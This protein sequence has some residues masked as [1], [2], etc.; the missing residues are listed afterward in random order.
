M[1]K[2][3]AER[4]RKGGKARSEALSPQRRGEIAKAAADTR[5]KNHWL[6][7]Q[8]SSESR[9]KK[10]AHGWRGMAAAIVEHFRSEPLNSYTLNQCSDV[11][12]A[13]QG[14]VDIWATLVKREIAELETREEIDN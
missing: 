13:L 6:S 3:H 11:V 7:K 8:A 12:D 5:W 1:P 10:K 9:C 4:G 2:D 14:V